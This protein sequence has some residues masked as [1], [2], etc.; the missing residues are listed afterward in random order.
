MTAVNSIRYVFGLDPGVVSRLTWMPNDYG[1]A[2][3]AAL[4]ASLMKAR[5]EHAEGEWLAKVRDEPAKHPQETRPLW[6][7]LFVAMLRYEN[8]EAYDAARALARVAARNSSADFVLLYTLVTRNN[9]AGSR[10]VRPVEGAGVE[11]SPALPGDELTLIRDAFVSVG[12]SNPDWLYGAVAISVFEEL[13]KAG[14]SAELDAFYREFV[15]NATTLE[16]INFASTMASE[17]GDM[18]A[19]RKLSDAFYRTPPGERTPA[20]SL[21]PYLVRGPK[22]IASLPAYYIA[23]VMPLKAEARDYDAILRLVDEAMTAQR[24]PSRVAERSRAGMVPALST[25][26]APVFAVPDEV[27]LV[28]DVPPYADRLPDGGPVPRRRDH[29]AAA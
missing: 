23:R 21:Q 5:R 8:R 2:R 9:P 14:R 4:A 22:G 3:M 17:R 26:G 28:L 15:A 11:P 25:N 1:Q 13:A 12:N 16:R 10:V 6:D 19:L 20:S 7:A 24:N 18:E 27:F 29:P